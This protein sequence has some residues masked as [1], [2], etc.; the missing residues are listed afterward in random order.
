MVRKAAKKRIVRKRSPVTKLYLCGLDHKWC[1]LREAVEI[2][3]VNTT[4]TKIKGKM[5]EAYEDPS[6]GSFRVRKV[7]KEQDITVHVFTGGTVL[8]T[9]PYRGL[10]GLGLNPRVGAAI[11]VPT[12][13]AERIR[14]RCEAEHANL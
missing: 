10:F 9:V 12:P 7:L 11:P 8:A 3:T 4:K 1:Q 2:P 14:I 6:T 13:L 5:S